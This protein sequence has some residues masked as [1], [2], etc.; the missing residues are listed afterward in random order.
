M[1]CVNFGFALGFFII[2]LVLSIITPQGF[3]FESPNVLILDDGSG[4][5]ITSENPYTSSPHPY[6]FSEQWVLTSL[7]GDFDSFDRQIR[8]QLRGYRKISSHNVLDH[9]TRRK[10]YDLIIQ[11]PGIT[12][13]RLAEISQCNESTLRYHLDKISQEKY[14][15]R[16]HNGRSSHFFENHNT[17]S[18]EEQQFL[19]RF[20][21]GLT[22]NIL[23]LIHESP[24]ITR[25]E[26]AEKLG[27]T[28]PT[29]TRAVL[30]LAEE[31]WVILLKEGRNT[32]HYLPGERGYILQKE[33][34]DSA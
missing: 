31:K 13:G 15:I 32:R 10:V 12:L 18:P 9:E 1:R 20:S 23:Q 6:R 5:H 7:L 25:K 17:F 19:S 34:A 33:I 16:V 26:I 3:Y 29:I 21:S 30:H 2:P 8:D 22:G 28:S 14:I 27:V 24:G 11:N 4:E